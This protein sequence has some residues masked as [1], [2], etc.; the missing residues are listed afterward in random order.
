MKHDIETGAR[1]LLLGCAN[2]NSGEKLL[3]VGE[4]GDRPYFDPQL[5]DYVAEVARNLGIDTEIQLAIPGANADQFPKSVANAMQQA[6]VTIF[7]SRLG[8][9]V[10][11][12]PS[13]GPGRKIMTYT[14]T[15]E[16][17][18]SMF[19]TVDYQ[20]MKQVH[21]RLLQQI[22]NSSAYS[23]TAP[24][25]T[26]LSATI[27]PAS[28]SDKAAVS[29]F[30]LD[31]FPVMIFPPLNFS[32]LN[33]IL[34]LEHFLLSSSTRAYADSELHLDTPVTVR[35]EDCCI[36]DFEGDERLVD[37]VQH[38]LKRA[39]SITGGDPYRL[40]SWHTGINPY[41]FFQG[42]PYSDLERWGT[43]AY[44]SPRYTHIHGA[45]K[46]P[47]DISIQLFDASIVFDD[48]AFWEQGKFIYL[49]Q[50]EIQSL[51][52]SRVHRAPDSSTRL[53]IGM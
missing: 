2:I 30:S 13:P 9:Q 18:G 53:S 46:E 31:L 22:K 19:S 7:F 15:L 45:G 17:L 42:D 21:D 34:V 10:R 37:K 23:I 48:K 20:M 35:I 44:G 5:C 11:F 47:G 29:E 24:N 40:N 38:Q 12:V 51:F 50:P 1:N 25:G 41:T 4:E 52:D 3:L 43:V 26:S 6:D 49:D 32:N 28:S 14:I 36:V 8:D 39:A 16:H 27:T 33:G